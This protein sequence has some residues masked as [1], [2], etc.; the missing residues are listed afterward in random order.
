MDTMSHALDAMSTNATS[1]DDE[2]S[3]D[4]LGDLGNFD[5]FTDSEA[6]DI[7]PTDCPYRVKEKIFFVPIDAFQTPISMG[8]LPSNVV[9]AD[10][11]HF[12]NAPRGPPSPMLNALSPSLSSVNR[13][14]KNIHF[15]R[16]VDELHPLHSS[17]PPS[18]TS[19]PLHTATSPSPPPPLITSSVN[20]VVSPDPPH[21]DEDNPYG[22]VGQIDLDESDSDDAGLIMEPNYE[23]QHSDD[24]KEETGCQHKKNK[25]SLL[26]DDRDSTK[27]LQRVS[28]GSRAQHNVK[29]KGSAHSKTYQERIVSQFHPKEFD[30]CL[31]VSA[32]LMIKNQRPSRD[33]D[34]YGKTKSVRMHKQS[35]GYNG[36]EALC[37][38][39]R[40]S[41]PDRLEL[42]QTV[43][44]TLV[45]HNIRMR[46][47][48]FTATS[49]SLH[50]LA[51][52]FGGCKV[53]QF[54]GYCCNPRDPRDQQQWPELCK[55][56]SE[57]NYTED[58]D[59]VLLE[60]EVG[61]DNED[62]N[63]CCFG[64][65]VWFTLNELEELLTAKQTQIECIIAMSPQHERLCRVFK[66]LGYDY[67]VGVEAPN[68]G[69][70]FPSTE[71]SA[72]LDQF[73]AALLES[74]SVSRAYYLSLQAALSTRGGGGGSDDDPKYVLRLDELLQAR[75]FI[76]FDP[77]D[78]KRSIGEIEDKSQHEKLPKTNLREVVRPFMGRSNYV[79]DLLKK[80]TSTSIV[81]V[82]GKELIGRASAVKW[83]TRY[84]LQMGFFRGGC[85]VIDC[86]LQSRKYKNKSFNE[87][88]F[89]VLRSCGVMFRSPGM[90]HSTA[91]S[92]YLDD[93]D[94]LG[95]GVPQMNGV[96]ASHGDTASLPSNNSNSSGAGS[97]SGS[98]S[99]GQGQSHLSRPSSGHYS[100]R[101]SAVFPHFPIHTIHE[102]SNTN[103][104]NPASHS[105]VTP[106]LGP[107][108]PPM[109]PVTPILGDPRTS[110]KSLF[111]YLDLAPPQHEPCC[112]LILN[113]DDW[114]NGNGPSDVAEWIQIASE[115]LLKPQ[116]DSRIIYTSL[117]AL[118]VKAVS[119]LNMKA[120]PTFGRDKLARLFKYFCSDFQSQFAPSEEAIAAHDALQDIFGGLP[121]MTKRVAQYVRFMIAEN[122]MAEREEE[123]TDINLDHIASLYPMSEFARMGSQKQLVA[124]STNHGKVQ[125]HPTPLV[126]KRT[127]NSLPP[128][129]IGVP[130]LRPI[131]L[132]Q[133]R[134]QSQTPKRPETF[135]KSPATDTAAM[136]PLVPDHPLNIKLPRTST[137]PV[138]S[139]HH[140]Y[141][142]EYYG[143]YARVPQHPHAVHALHG[144]S[145]HHTVPLQL[146]QHLLQHAHPHQLPHA[147]P[148][149]A[150]AVMNGG[151]D[152][153]Y[154]AKMG[155]MNT[156][157]TL[158]MNMIPS[159]AG[160]LH[161]VGQHQFQ[162]Y[163]PAHSQS[164]LVNADIAAILQPPIQLENTC[165]SPGTLY[166]DN[167][168]LPT[169]DLL[170]NQSKEV[171]RKPVEFRRPNSM[172][173]PA[174]HCDSI[175]L[176]TPHRGVA[177]SGPSLSLVVTSPPLGMDR[178]TVFFPHDAAE[179]ATPTMNA[180]SHIATHHVPSHR[181]RNL[182][183]SISE[184]VS[185]RIGVDIHKSVEL[186]DHA[187]ARLM[188][189]RSSSVPH[190][191]STHLT[192]ASLMAHARNLPS[193][194]SSGSS[195]E[196]NSLS[197]DDSKESKE[198]RDSKQRFHINVPS[199]NMSGGKHSYNRS[200]LL[201]PGHS[202]VFSSQI[203]L[204]ADSVF[205]PP[206]H[207]PTLAVS[208]SWHRKNTSY[209]VYSNSKPSDSSVTTTE[210]S[211][212]ESTVNSLTPTITVHSNTTGTHT[213]STSRN[214][215]PL[216]SAM[217]TSTLRLT[218]P[219]VG[220]PEFESVSAPIMY[221]NVSLTAN[222]TKFKAMAL[223]DDTVIGIQEY[224]ARSIWAKSCLPTD[225]MKAR[226]VDLFP[227]LVDEFRRLTHCETRHPTAQ[228]IGEYFEK[229][230]GTKAGVIA[231]NNFNRF[232]A[233]FRSMCAIL[234]DLRHIYVMMEDYLIGLFYGRTEAEDRLKMKPEGTFLLRLASQQNG[235]AITYKSQ[236][237][238][239]KNVLLTRIDSEKY[240]VGK[241]DKVEDLFNLIRS[242]SKLQ[243]AYTPN[244]LIRKKFLF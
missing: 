85:F 79:L 23:N 191:H 40:S 143:Q 118:Q 102:R 154:V 225:N 45:R 68:N 122:S 66:A 169:T 98:G 92:P 233:W 179:R 91:L 229:C 223:M 138:S 133:S 114:T 176:M 152:G 235:L 210:T 89:D 231:A 58:S 82:T 31:M 104:T 100:C 186:D 50:R 99:G 218:H 181:L 205:E 126:C 39:I 157:H 161:N 75:K 165:T 189:R 77:V 185:N 64:K 43:R 238:K 142:Y 84:L 203:S 55:S 239:M 209:L 113:V 112:L 78:I 207:S 57:G 5:D 172:P 37:E 206:T 175:R 103:H 150:M 111:E 215:G 131:H 86:K 243:Y 74:R 109:G 174:A 53:L 224:K 202:K 72:F 116:E 194:R 155:S 33:H 163:S 76:V 42:Q 20:I 11:H 13:H 136:N 230:G 19:P 212:H 132:M 87:C 208:S 196:S 108:T 16:S 184:D 171:P 170:I 18:P 36:S 80:L 24:S 60:T 88:V 226:L 96:A 7:G 190:L 48:N 46:Y 51:T 123:K 38:Y 83:T 160:F 21:C 26:L 119:T 199:S 17:S 105:V 12:Q 222:N 221:D 129:Q 137:P 30:I 135:F 180:E 56:L 49:E 211:D 29:G 3:A 141:G 227:H 145:H 197:F 216:S 139:A 4:P 200:N 242:W 182:N 124:V 63:I 244:K 2:E 241:S 107:I 217:G 71:T 35:Q 47:A 237:G 120:L 213:A 168:Y 148:Q 159:H 240:K 214:A 166:D 27:Q 158:N 183:K 54:V 110:P 6:D 101:S 117:E 192:R 173:S 81:N 153:P 106:P 232:F 121:G 156:I 228:Q 147:L 44:Q 94:D 177:P 164:K 67:V 234:R 195:T 130:P 201:R 65:G 14:N 140:H 146:H 220:T 69:H 187:L 204:S 127:S 125:T 1:D 10:H 59:Y 167:Y 34:G 128:Q 134:Q 28:M 32:P 151:V 219:G 188:H 9:P 97:A 70:P 178:D 62:D 22:T 15:R 25:R 198:S 41:L 73:Y 144:H 193:V 95:V 115:H 8:D 162:P 52:D 93:D 149:N 90:M 61:T 236:S